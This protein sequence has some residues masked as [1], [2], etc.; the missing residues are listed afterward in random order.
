MDTRHKIL[1]SSFITMRKYLA[2]PFF[3][4]SLLVEHTRAIISN[5]SSVQERELFADKSCERSIPASF[6]PLSYAHNYPPYRQ[7]VEQALVDALNIA[8]HT[9]D[10][11]FQTSTAYSHYFQP[12]EYPRVQRMY[13]SMINILETSTDKIIYKCGNDQLP[14]VYWKDSTAVTSSKAGLIIF[15]DI[16]FN[17]QSPVY[18]P[19]LD[20]RPF[21][22]TSSGWC[23]SRKGLSYFLVNGAIVLHELS[24][25]DIVGKNADMPPRKWVSFVEFMSCALCAHFVLVL[26]LG[27]DCTALWMCTALALRVTNGF[28][29]RTVLGK[30]LPPTLLTLV[31][32]LTVAAA[33]SLKQLWDNYNTDKRTYRPILTAGQ[34]AESYSAAALEWYF[35][36]RCGFHEIRPYRNHWLSPPLSSIQTIQCPTCRRGQTIPTPTQHNR[37]T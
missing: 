21:D 18:Q 13:Q 22:M 31:L 29:S 16:F 7:K 12:E 34:N 35:M 27:G 2:A 9:Q 25:L 20:D 5:S 23:Q 17:T 1:Y 8:R 33:R 11:R 32:W 30:V 4:I 36:V 10:T 6:L 14:H 15:C 3:S 26:A 37:L 19:Y 28:L 24:H